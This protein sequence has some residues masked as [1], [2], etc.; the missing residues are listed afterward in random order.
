MKAPLTLTL[1]MYDITHDRTLQKVAKLLEKHGFERINYSVWLGWRGFAE[2]SVLRNE[3]KKLLGAEIAKGSRL[4]SIP[5]KSHT[6][7]KMRSITGHKPSELDYWLGEK[8][9]LFL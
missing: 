2:N 6:L 5:L 3:L 8:K 4:Y 9:L 7:K 1:V